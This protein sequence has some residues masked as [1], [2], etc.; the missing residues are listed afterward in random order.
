MLTRNDL[1]L[2][3]FII[4][5]SILFFVITSC[6][7][8]AQEQEDESLNDWIVYY[9]YN[10]VGEGRVVENE[11]V[12][13]MTLDSA[14][15]TYSFHSVN[16]ELFQGGTY[17]PFS[18]EGSHGTFSASLI[19]ADIKNLEDI[20][21]QQLQNMEEGAFI[22]E[23]ILNKDQSAE[24]ESVVSDVWGMKYQIQVQHLADNQIELQLN[25]AMPGMIQYASWTI[26]KKLC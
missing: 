8:T 12:A 25:P 3:K 15:S 18:S 9:S 10:P 20:N 16:Q 21:C 7:K 26:N 13:I 22:G 2:K 6:N 5:L 17:I 1:K 19:G 24:T 11:P 4:G 23:L 14:L